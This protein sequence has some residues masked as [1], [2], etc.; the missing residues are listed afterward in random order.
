MVPALLH[1]STGAVTGGTGS[2]KS[3]QEARVVYTQG[4]ILLGDTLQS[5]GLFLDIL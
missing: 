4:Q 2:W 3:L 5:S 1:R